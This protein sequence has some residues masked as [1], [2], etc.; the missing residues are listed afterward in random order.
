M[1][2]HA[3]HNTRRLRFSIRRHGNRYIRF[4]CKRGPHFAIGPHSRA[5]AVG[6]DDR[7]IDTNIKC[8][9]IWP[10]NKILRLQ[11]CY[12][13]QLP[14]HSR[15]GGQ[16]RVA[17]R[18]TGFHTDQARAA[19]FNGTKN[20]LAPVLINTQMGFRVICLSHRLRQTDSYRQGGKRWP[21]ATKHAGLPLY[22]A[23]ASIITMLRPSSIGRDSTF[24]TS[25]T[26][27]ATRSISCWATS[28]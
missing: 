12:I 15:T 3:I 27:F 21:A 23:G 4:A 17:N 13:P 9:A 10:R 7:Q 8:I 22:V 20:G 1:N 5:V 11:N 14:F 19:K 2:R 25:E 26:S 16:W 6:S 18:S 28:G 24:T